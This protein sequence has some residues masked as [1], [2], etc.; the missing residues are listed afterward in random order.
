LIH[1]PGG[2]SVE[3]ARAVCASKLATEA[4]ADPGDKKCALFHDVFSNCCFNGQCAVLAA[5]AMFVG[6]TTSSITR[7]ALRVRGYPM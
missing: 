4:A 7:S 6:G 3:A 2:E 5:L 1:A